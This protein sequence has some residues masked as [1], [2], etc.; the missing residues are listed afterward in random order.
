[1]TDWSVFQTDVLDVLRQYQGY[2]DFFER[3][4]SLSDSRPDCFARVTRE[5]KKE[6]WII[7]AKNK[8]EV[9]SEDLERM[10]K[11]VGMVKGNPVDVGLE[12]SELAEHDIR[13]IFVTTPGASPEGYEQVDFPK[14]HQFLQ[15]ELV[16]TDTEKVVRDV[17]KMVEREQLSHSQARLLFNSIK[18]FERR[19][20]R[21]IKKLEDLEREFVGL[22]LEKP[23]LDS[24]DYNI[25]VDAVVKH[26]RRNEIFLFDVPYSEDSVDEIEDKVEEIKSRIEE[27]ERPVYYTVINTFPER[28]SNYLSRPG[29]L[30]SDIR[31]TAGIVSPEEV[32]ELFTPKIPVER[33]YG[34]SYVEIRDRAGI[35]IRARVESVDD[36]EHSIEVAMPEEAASSVKDQFLN[37]REI[38]EMI[39]N[40]FR[41]NI[42]ITPELEVQYSQG[43][44]S[45]ESFK[46]AVRSVY[47]S[48]VNPVVGRKVSRTV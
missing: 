32:L 17:A 31:E 48:A 44:E 41:E 25:P 14:L 30:R 10:E 47:Q 22:E 28:D 5:N 23:P 11:Y 1:M 21:G 19:V 8:G 12:L 29:E 2:F 42:E 37:T 3:V 13:G 20:S 39:G 40:R 9:D 35:G 34:D 24:Y 45:L 6:I 4:G 26:S 46:E 36:V 43:E 27:V 18:P 15:R 16:Y 38:G 7:D 33:E